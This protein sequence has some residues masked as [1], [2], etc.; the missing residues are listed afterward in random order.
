MNKKAFILSIILIGIGLLGSLVS[1][2]FAIPQIMNDV[3]SKNKEKYNVD[4][5]V[6]ESPVENINILSTGNGSVRVIVKKS[7]N[8]KLFIKTTNSFMNDVN[9]NINYDEKSNTLNIDERC[10]GTDNFKIM[11][12]SNFVNKAY[13]A[14]IESFSNRNHHRNEILIETPQ[15]VNFECTR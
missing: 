4:E 6:V 9:I 2:L 15:K 12:A 1:G 7:N 13:E 5:K 3:S 14:M 10:D 11:N 8:D